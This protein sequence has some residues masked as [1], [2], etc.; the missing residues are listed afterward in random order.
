MNSQSNFI[1]VISKK[2][3]DLAWKLSDESISSQEN[4]TGLGLE[5]LIKLT[6]PAVPAGMIEEGSRLMVRI[7]PKTKGNTL[8]TLG[9]NILEVNST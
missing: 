6:R 5:T 9:T 4:K 1:L 7:I 8:V 3:K 2:L